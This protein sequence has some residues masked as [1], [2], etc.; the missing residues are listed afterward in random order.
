MGFVVL[1]RTTKVQKIIRFLGLVLFYSLFAGAFSLAYGN[2]GPLIAFWCL[3]FNR[4]MVIFTGPLSEEAK[5]RMQM[6]WVLGV[7]LYV[8]LAIVT[9]LLPIPQLGIS[10][11][12]VAAQGFEMSGEW[13]EHPQ[14]VLAFGFLYFGLFGTVEL[15]LARRAAKPASE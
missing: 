15:L 1:S 4:I 3:S 7:F 11:K 6:D 12:F 5:S 10:E 13:V 14:R 2:W 9:T 8:V